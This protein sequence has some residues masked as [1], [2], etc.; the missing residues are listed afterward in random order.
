MC[1]DQCSSVWA[2]RGRACGSGVRFRG[3]QTF[4]EPQALM[5]LSP[6]LFPPT[7]RAW[8]MWLSWGSWLICLL[9]TSSSGD[10]VCPSSSS[11]YSFSMLSLVLT[12]IKRRHLPSLLTGTRAMAGWGFWTHC[13]DT[14]LVR[15]TGTMP[16][17][18]SCLWFQGVDC[19]CPDWDM[20]CWLYLLS[21]PSWTLT[22]SWTEEAEGT[23][24]DF[25]NK[26]FLVASTP[27]VQ[28]TSFQWSTWFP[29]DDFQT[30]VLA[31]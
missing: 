12:L 25:S 19:P 13:M 20:H 9:P 15:T 28:E 17:L 6:L 29:G 27:D 10:F 16:P 18:S 23:C 5:T 4:S 31:W 24:W 11:M 26:G 3:L 7:T 8:S 1:V 2:L 14:G 30:G 21:L 22:S